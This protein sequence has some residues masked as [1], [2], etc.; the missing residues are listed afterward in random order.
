[1]P[2]SADNTETMQSYKHDKANLYSKATFFWLTPLLWTG[3][4]SPLEL[5]DMGK[6]PKEEETEQ[7]FEKFNAIYTSERVLKILYNYSLTM[8]SGHNIDLTE[9]TELLLICVTTCLE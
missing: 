1:V 9:V 6:L 3:Y 8:Y 7:Q 4:T 5:E 2:N